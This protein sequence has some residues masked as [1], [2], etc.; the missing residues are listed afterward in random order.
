MVAL[1]NTLG[2]EMVVVEKIEPMNVVL[3][4]QMVTPSLTL[5]R[6]SRE[7]K[8]MLAERQLSV[9]GPAMMVSPAL[10]HQTGTQTLTLTWT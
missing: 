2:V 8:E 10:Q 1:M 4:L 3:L 6:V 7:I 9:P 5:V